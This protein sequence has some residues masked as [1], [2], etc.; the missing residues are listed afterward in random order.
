MSCLARGAVRERR[1][2]RGGVAREIV[3]DRLPAGA[4][5]LDGVFGF[6]I[7]GGG[8]AGAAADRLEGGLGAPPVGHD[9]GDAAFRFDDVEDRLEIE[10]EAAVLRLHPGAVSATRAQVDLGVRAVPVGRGEV[11]A[12]DM[13]GLGPGAPGGAGRGRDGG[14]DRDLLESHGVLLRCRQNVASGRRCVNR[15]GAGTG[16]PCR[17]PHFPVYRRAAMP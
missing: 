2:E 5:H 6:R 13:G 14:G 1:S 10:A 16:P 12:R 11:P 4:L 3:E 7:E 15:G 17:V 8:D 9:E